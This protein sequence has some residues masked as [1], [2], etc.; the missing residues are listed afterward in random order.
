M[1]D[2]DRLE[3]VLI[4]AARERRPVTYAQLL[5]YFDRRVGP[6]N[7]RALCRDLGHVCR[8]VAAKGG[9]DLACLVVRKSDGLPGIGYFTDDE[10]PAGADPIELIAARQEAAFDWAE[11]QPA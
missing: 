7:V 3:R 5:A 4:A 6:A 11:D 9:P 10:I 8:A 2:L 1:V